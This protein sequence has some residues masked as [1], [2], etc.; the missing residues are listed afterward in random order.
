MNAGSVQ[1]ARHDFGAYR[2]CDRIAKFDGL[3]DFV[4]GEDALLNQQL[5]Q[6][7]AKHLEIGVNLFI[8]GGRRMRVPVIMFLNVVVMMMRVFV[9]GGHCGIFASQCS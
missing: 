1:A 2:R 5:F 9:H 6:R 7:E 8:L 4:G 3:A